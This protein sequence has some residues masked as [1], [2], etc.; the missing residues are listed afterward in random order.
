MEAVVMARVAICFGF[1]YNLKVHY[2]SD[3]HI[4]K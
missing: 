4:I 3:L 2:K 1:E